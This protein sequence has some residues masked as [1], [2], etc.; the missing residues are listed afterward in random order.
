MREVEYHDVAALHVAETGQT[1]VVALDEVRIGLPAENRVVDK[2]YG[3]RSLGQLGAVCKLAYKQVVSCHQ[4]TFHR[5]GGYAES[6]ENEDIER[7]NHDDGEDDG[8]EP[9]QP[10]I[11]LFSLLIVLLPEGPLHLPGDE[12]I[13]NHQEA[14]K[15]PVISEPDHPEEVE[16]T[17]DSE[18]E[19][20]IM[21]ELFHVLLRCDYFFTELI[22]A[23]KA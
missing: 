6:L 3:K 15:P 16:D 9:V 17:P 13:E 21:Q 2:G 14:E 1:P 7:N 4:S 10:H 8:V 5:R 22:T 19:P 20:L 11:A 23:S 18:P 12:D